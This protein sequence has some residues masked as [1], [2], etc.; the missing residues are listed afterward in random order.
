M[1][2]CS[3]PT[4]F[5][6]GVPSQPFLF[7]SVMAAHSRFTQLAR[8]LKQLL[9]RTQQLMLI[10]LNSQTDSFNRFLESLQC[11]P[12]L[13]EM[14]QC[15]TQ[16]HLPT[17]A[18]S[19]STYGL[20]TL[21]VWSSRRQ[22]TLTPKRLLILLVTHSFVSQTVWYSRHMVTHLSSF[23]QQ[24]TMALLQTHLPGILILNQLVPKVLLVL[25]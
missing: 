20:T 4:R 12:S 19:V 18:L 10:K 11:L 16:N 21:N 15:F 24:L 7:A 23:T 3:E 13:L 9:H 2:T 22:S 17:R 25:F 8:T 6:G 14:L 1:L 5:T